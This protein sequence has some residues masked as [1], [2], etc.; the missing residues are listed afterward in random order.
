MARLRHEFRYQVMYNCTATWVMCDS[1]AVAREEFDDVVAG[2]ECVVVELIK[3][4]GWEYLERWLSPHITPIGRST[5]VMA[6]IPRTDGCLPADEPKS[7]GL[8]WRQDLTVKKGRLATK[9]PARP[10]PRSTS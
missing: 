6:A 5:T 4:N 10:E 8:I 3:R 9:E 7:G 1:L 2:G